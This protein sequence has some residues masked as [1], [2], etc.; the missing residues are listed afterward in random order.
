LNFPLL[1]NE[2]GVVSPNRRKFRQ[3]IFHD[4]FG[5]DRIGSTIAEALSVKKAQ[6]QILG[7]PK[8]TLQKSKF[9][10]NEDCTSL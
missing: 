4:I 7:K 9:D 8:G 6:G 2:T 1:R 10:Q 5:P 3:G